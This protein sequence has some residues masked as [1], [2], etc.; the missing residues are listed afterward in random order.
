MSN[1][2]D[3]PD[4]CVEPTRSLDRNGH[5][6]TGCAPIQAGVS[7]RHNNRGVYRTPASLPGP[8][9]TVPDPGFPRA[10]GAIHTARPNHRAGHR[11]KES[12]FDRPGKK[13]AAGYEP[14]PDELRTRCQ[15]QGGK[16]VAVA[17]VSKVFVDGVTVDALLRPLTML[18]VGAM[19]V[20]LPGFKPAQGYDG[21]LE[22]V[23]ERF[24]C[25]LCPDEGRMHWKNKKDA[26]PH[27]RKFHFGLADRCIDW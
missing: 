10:V 11:Y 21:F 2:S 17:W 16:N 1:T 14:D 3:W 7:T 26:V 27:L 18:E 13:V 23:N 24:E 8:T 19:S 6:S 9:F 4:Q 20:R 22:R 25:G 12:V 5:T 15:Q